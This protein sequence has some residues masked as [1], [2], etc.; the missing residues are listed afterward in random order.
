M[1]QTHGPD[2]TGFERTVLPQLERALIA[3]YDIVLLGNAGRVKLDY[4]APWP[5]C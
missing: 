4:F 3:G 1:G 5:V 2:C